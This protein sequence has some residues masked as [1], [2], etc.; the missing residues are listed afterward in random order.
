MLITGDHNLGADGNLTPVEGFVTAPTHYRPD[1]TV[2]LGTKFLLN[3]GVS[4]LNTMHVMQGN[5][6]LADG[7]VQH[8][9]RSSLQAALSNSG[10]SGGITNFVSGP[11]GVYGVFAN[12]A[13]CSGP[14]LN[15]I[16][17]P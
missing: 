10:D 17:F 13:G 8:F 3:A 12:P 11:Y 1:Y 14:L 16:Q 9:K 6:G 15:R 4:W 5:V 2:S 7:S